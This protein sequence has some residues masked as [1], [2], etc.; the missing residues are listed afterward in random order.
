MTALQVSGPV[1][2]FWSLH[3]SAVPD[4]G[5][6]EPL[7]HVPTPVHTLLS[8]SH[9]A[10]SGLSVKLQMAA[11]ALQKGIVQLFGAGHVRSRQRAS[12]RSLPE[13]KAPPAPMSHVSG[14]LV[15]LSPQVGH[16]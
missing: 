10:S 11:S 15:W 1:Q 7:S 8:G 13:Q 6:H 5:L 14:K 9:G 12:H 4:V 3:W 16:G 2:G